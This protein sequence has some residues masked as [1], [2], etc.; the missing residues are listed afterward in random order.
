MR[1][2]ALSAVEAG[3]DLIRAMVERGVDLSGVIAL[4]GKGDMTDI[5]G[6][7]DPAA[8]IAPLSLPIYYVDDY[9]LRTESDRALLGSLDIDVLIVVGWQRLV[10]KWLIQSCSTA[11]LGLH[12]SAGG[13]TGGRGR[14][15]QNWALICGSPHFE[16]ALFK[17]D[18]GVDS[19]SVLASRRFDYTDH[20]DI[21]SSYQKS[22]LLGADMI[23]TAARD[24]PNELVRAVAQDEGSA[25]YLP[26]RVANDGV[27]DWSLPAYQVRR[28]VAALTRPYPG[29]FSALG[30]GIIKIWNARPIGD[31]PLDET[32]AP[33]K[34]VHIAEKRGFIIRVGDSY[35]MVDDFELNEAA[36][37]E[38]KV[39]VILQSVP[40]HLTVSRIIERHR[41]RSP[42]QPLNADII[43]LASGGTA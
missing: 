24:W 23:A 33:G 29:A 1:V 13:I 40:I 19:G 2:F 27:I 4:S 10:P 14:S 37:A 5:A 34:I 7:S 42:D 9:R 8:V 30:A 25:N 16:I 6:Y 11:V 32:A 26:Q 15:P 39:G 12:G 38:F 36:Q 28:N 3:V 20:D 21:V 22:L 43:A 18:A 41:L 35:M 31:I 17:I